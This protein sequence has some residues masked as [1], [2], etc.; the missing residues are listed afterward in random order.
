[1]KGL[2]SVKT[3]YPNSWTRSSLNFKPC[4][5]QQFQTYMNQIELAKS[6]ATKAHEGQ[7][8]F[9]GVTAYIKHPEKVASILEGK[10]EEVI[11]T[12]WLHDVLEDTTETAQSLKKQGVSDEVIEAVV[13]LTKQKDQGY[14]RYLEIVKANHIARRVKIADMLANLS[15][16]PTKKQV[17]KYAKGLI[18][19]LFDI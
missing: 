19:L 16:S 18:D 10:S 6:I 3:T 17:Q 13:C 7:F 4:Q 9:D 8:R 14:T 15:D 2:K 11:A 5:S 1:M 12:A